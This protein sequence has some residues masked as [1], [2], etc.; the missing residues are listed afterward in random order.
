MKKSKTNTKIKTKTNT[1]V[2]VPYAQ[3]VY[4]KEEIKAVNEVLADPGKIVAGPRIKLFEEKIATIFGKKHGIMV[5][6]GSAANLIALEVAN[7]PK[8]SEVITPILTFATTVAP[9]VQKGLVP[10]FVDVEPGSYLIDIK[11]IEALITPQTKAFMI[12]SLI[13][14]L[15]DFVALQKLAKKHNCVLIEDSCDTLGAS[16][17]GKPT[18]FYTDMSTTSFYASHIITAAGGGGMVC[19]HDDAHARRA[20]VMANWGRES[21]LF[22]FY[23]KSEELEKRF[24]G[25]LDGEMYDAKFL[26]TEVGYNFQATELQGAFGLEQLKRLGKF[27]AARKKNFANLYKFFEKYEKFFTLPKQDPKAEVVWLAFPLTLKADLPFTRKDITEYLE[28]HDIQTRPIF[29]GNIL[30]QPG[31]KNI[32]CKTVKEGYPVTEHIMR[33]GFLVGCHHGLT[34]EGIAHLKKTITDFLNPFLQK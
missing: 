22:G 30:K 24:A 26:F 20:R 33:N 25:R 5:S 1:S 2:R 34:P 23:E 7:L 6:S 29:T 27:K 4:G 14:N 10:V 12:P 32:E 16:F 13:G 31:F 3:T 8:G 28:K 17:A 15:P 18:G 11:K 21:T 9:L 19:F